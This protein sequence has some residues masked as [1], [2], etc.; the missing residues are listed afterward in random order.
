MPTGRAPQSL[1]TKMPINTSFYP[2][3]WKELALTVKESKNWCCE[4]CGKRCYKPG[5][6]P[7]NLTRRDRKESQSNDDDIDLIKNKDDKATQWRVDVVDDKKDRT[8]RLI[9]K[10]SIDDG[11]RKFLDGSTGYARVYLS[12][13]V[14]PGFSG[15]QWKVDNV[16]SSEKVIALENQG[17]EET[18]YRWLSCENGKVQL[19]TDGGKDYLSS[20]WKFDVIKFGSKN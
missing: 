12:K 10:D 11:E 17:E 14:G 2:S 8:I 20:K 6:R 4:C 16:D 19:D 3:N 5:Q 18:G 15:T 9:L 13:T 1:L 7:E